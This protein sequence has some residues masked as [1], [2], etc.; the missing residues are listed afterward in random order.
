MTLRQTTRGQLPQHCDER[1]TG[2]KLRYRLSDQKGGCDGKVP[3][4]KHRSHVVNQ[5]GVSTTG[6]QCC[7]PR[8]MA[9]WLAYAQQSPCACAGRATL[10]P[11]F[12]LGVAAHG[13]NGKQVELTPSPVRMAAACCV[14]VTATP[15]NRSGES[16]NIYDASRSGTRPGGIHPVCRLPLAMGQTAGWCLEGGGIAPGGGVIAT[17]SP[18]TLKTPTAGRA[19]TLGKHRRRRQMDDRV[20]MAHTRKTH[21]DVTGSFTRPAVP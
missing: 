11:D 6:W 7:L 20:L 14:R 8:S 4:R 2:G 16:I 18:G 17:A 21:P 5:T 10:A 15:G 3:D 9:R 1:R 12:W 13:A 19:A